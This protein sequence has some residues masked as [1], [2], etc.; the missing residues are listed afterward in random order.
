MGLDAEFER[1]L[2]EA[3]GALLREDAAG[4]RQSGAAA[5]RL[6][7][8]LG[9]R[10]L[11][12]RARVVYGRTLVFAGS[13]QRGLAQLDTAE[14]L[15]DRADLGAL[16]LERSALLYKMGAPAASLAACR[17]ALQALPPAAFEERARA[18]NNVGIMCLYLGQLSQARD[19]F[20]EAE[21]L[22]RQDGR[23]LLAAQ[24]HANLAM[25]LARLGD[26]VGALGAFDA[27]Q[28][29]MRHLG[30]PQGQH[31]VAR[32]EVLLDAGLLREVRR[33]LPPAIE[34]LDGSE[35]RADAAEGL[36]YLA[37]G[38]LR[39]GDRAAVDAARAAAER[40]RQMGSRGWEAIAGLVE[41][42]ARWLAG[43]VS[44][45]TLRAAHRTAVT[46]GQSGLRVHQLEAELVAGRLADALGRT[47]DARRRF[48]AV[49]GA[50]RAGAV[51]QRVIG[52]EALARLRLIDG[53]CA[54]AGRAAGAGLDVVERH[55]DTLAAT[56]LRAGASGHGV[57]LA[58]I[59][60]DL[61]LDRG[62]ARRVLRASERWR[63]RA[64]FRSALR[65]PAD[66]VTADLLSEL[67][68][69]ALQ[70]RDPSTPASV[71]ADLDRRAVS[72]EQAVAD[73][74]RQAAPASSSADGRRG[75]RLDLDALSTAL[76]DRVLV[77]YL[78]SAGRLAAVVLDGRRCRLVHLG[79]ANQVSGLVIAA[80]FALRKLARLGPASPAAPVALRGFTE[81]LAAL[82]A[83]VVDPVRPAI[84]GCEVVVVPTGGLHSV[85][86]PLVLGSGCVVA[87]APSA[88][89][90]LRATEAPLS[91]SGGVVLVAG[92]GL[93]GAVDEVGAISRHY[94]TCT[95]LT[96]PDATVSAVTKSIDGARLVHLAAHGDLRQ[97][98]PL[99]SS[100][101]LVDGPETVYDLEGL[102][103]APA[104]IVLSACESAV[105]EVDP[106]DEML[107]LAASLLG[108]GTR[109]AIAA[110]VP[111]PD[112][113]T[114]AL[115][116]GFHQRLAAGASPGAALAAMT[117]GVDGDDPGLVAASGAFV[118]LGAA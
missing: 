15:L 41:A 117:V 109:S 24:T 13:M 103:Q 78:E 50:R 26:L 11:E 5:V 16:F 101:R 54:G 4:A 49:A 47:G 29:E 48:A 25:V 43:D 75:S 59:V 65:P 107:G 98:S 111:I 10:A 112:L 36:L 2:A 19:A 93:P 114:V 3:R 84:D 91:P 9:D 73:R 80:L 38:R 105:S 7:K 115:M 56:D 44:E 52:W 42:Q 6:A 87:V 20:R 67:R 51:R 100:F 60:L 22:H 55:R 99:F 14:A 108:L 40:F 27:A 53:N 89:L 74:A 71:L 28:T 66:P 118:C 110:V 18:L 64:L 90:W 30:V 69:L 96:G 17:A 62:D 82:R 8:R 58:S 88:A 34:A 81:R 61:A 12:G 92:P 72:I 32:A 21:R 77:E 76:G 102:G 79:D 46:L 113:A 68:L 37:T 23:P 104:V 95:V 97:D 39:A 86:W 83:A 57:G 85:P 116:D 33:E 35:M 63:A 31:A 45:R 1:A 70:Q 94:P 106:G